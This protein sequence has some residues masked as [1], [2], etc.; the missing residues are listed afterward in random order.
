M[1]PMKMDRWRKIRK[2]IVA[3]SPRFHCR[4]AKD[5]ISKPK[6]TNS[7]ITLEDRHDIV[8]PPHCNARRR[9]YIAPRNSRTPKTSMRLNFVER[10]KER[11]E[12]FVPLI[13][14]KN[15]IK[16]STTAPM[17]TFLSFGQYMSTRHFKGT[18]IQK[19]HLQFTLSVKTP[20]STGPIQT[21]MAKEL[22]TIP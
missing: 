22:I 5:M 20:P 16:T 12:F 7:P 17:G 1:L 10:F 6:P 9:Q 11:F 13:R 3:C 18:Y 4:A 14:K 8:C 21:L 19:H 2:G 15:M